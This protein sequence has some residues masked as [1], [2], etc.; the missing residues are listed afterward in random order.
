MFA[1]MLTNSTSGDTLDAELKSL[2]SLILSPSR[3]VCH[4]LHTRVLL[5]PTWAI[6]AG[7]WI[8]MVLFSP[9]TWGLSRLPHPFTDTRAI[10]VHVYDAPIP[11][12][13]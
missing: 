10:T 6:F 3:L 11:W 8:S 9:Q 1:G 2:F 5:P 12:W 7:R 13:V 4:T